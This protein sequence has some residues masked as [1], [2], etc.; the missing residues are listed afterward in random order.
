VPCSDLPCARS[1]SAL[2]DGR[3]I[4]SESSCPDN[5]GTDQSAGSDLIPP[6]AQF[7][8]VVAAPPQL[9]AA[10]GASKCV[11]DLPLVLQRGARCIKTAMKSLRARR[12]A[13]RRAVWSGTR[14]PT[15]RPSRRQPH[16]QR[17]EPYAIRNVAPAC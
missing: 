11:N 8:K 5:N 1:R 10:P 2:A 17:L 12:G 4:G 6:R 7:Q 16:L 13:K 15:F 14:T 3:G 9:H